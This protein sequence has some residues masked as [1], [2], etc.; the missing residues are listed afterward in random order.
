LYKAQVQVV[1]GPPHKTSD[2]E[3]NR[4]EGGERAHGHRGEVPEQ[5]TSG[6]YSKIKKGDQRLDTSFFFRIGNKI[7]MEGVTET[8]IGAK[9]KGW[10]IQRLP[11]PVI[12][13]IISHQM[14]TLLHR[15][16]RF[17]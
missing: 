17:C 10:T 12:H 9:M 15:P 13:P 6:L 3:T 14:Q 4:K 5:N 1:Q 16:A 11:H 8:K 7:P 2:T